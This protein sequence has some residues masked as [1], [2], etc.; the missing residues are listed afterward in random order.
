[1]FQEDWVI[2]QVESIVNFLTTAV[3]NK[4]TPAFELSETF[5]TSTAD[6]LHAKLLKLIQENRINE[7][8]NL[9]FEKL[10]SNDQRYLEVAVDFYFKLNSFDD[11]TLHRCE[12]SREEIADGLKEVAGR[13]GIPLSQLFQPL[14]QEEDE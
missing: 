1:M 2:R 6:E 14:P 10:N 4:K 11:D 12:F 8:E 9:L 7:A 5:E 3:L 13:F